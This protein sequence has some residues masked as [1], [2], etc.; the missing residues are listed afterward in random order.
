LA[1]RQAGFGEMNKAYVAVFGADPPARITVGCSGLAL[2]AAVGMDCVA[3][4]PTSPPP[5]PDV[6]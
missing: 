2:G 4:R 3:F 5:L 6:S 1:S